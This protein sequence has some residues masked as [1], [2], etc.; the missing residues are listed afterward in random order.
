MCASHL[1]NLVPKEGDLIKMRT[2]IFLCF[3]LIALMLHKS[4]AGNFT[5]TPSD[6]DDLLA[7]NKRTLIY[8]I[9]GGVAKVRE[10]RRREVKQK[11]R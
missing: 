3:P 11:N 5:A 9:N 4:S 8:N 2:G 1:V 6:D 7:R 10:R